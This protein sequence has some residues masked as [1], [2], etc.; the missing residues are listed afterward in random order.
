L[1]YDRP[2]EPSSGPEDDPN[3]PVWSWGASEDMPVEVWDEDPEH[4]IYVPRLRFCSPCATDVDGTFL[5][6][7]FGYLFA[8]RPVLADFN[9]DGLANNFDI[10][11]LGYALG[12]PTE[13]DAR[14]GAVHGINLLG[15]GDANNDGAFNNFDI[16]LLV[17]E[18]L[19]GDNSNATAED[20]SV[21]LET[22]IWIYDH[23]QAEEGS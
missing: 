19:G 5:C 2:L 13:W 12:N 18:M 17:Q 9:G 8:L 10:T 11:P 15:V 16:G 22:V 4:R 6:A 7:S 23:F 3:E 21:F 20:W 1:A 14:W